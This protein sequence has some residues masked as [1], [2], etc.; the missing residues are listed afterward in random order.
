ML[1]SSLN[2]SL[3]IPSISV[4]KLLYKSNIEAPLITNSRLLFSQLILISNYCHEEKFSLYTLE[5][6]AKLNIEVKKIDIFNNQSNNN[7]LVLS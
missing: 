5:R 4:F 6:K 1:I 7:Y 2:C 3:E